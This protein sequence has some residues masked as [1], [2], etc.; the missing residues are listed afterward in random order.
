MQ[1]VYRQAGRIANSFVISRDANGIIMRK[2]DI[3][4]ER[5]EVVK[6]PDD[7]RGFQH[8]FDERDRLAAERP[9]PVTQ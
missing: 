4:L 2:T 9:T 6:D 5:W 7:L 8:L 1:V 3:V